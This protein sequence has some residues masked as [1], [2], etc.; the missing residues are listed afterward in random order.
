MSGHSKLTPVGKAAPV[1]AGK[2]S[3]RYRKT[4]ATWVIYHKGSVVESGFDS[5][6]SARDYLFD[7]FA[8]ATLDTQASKV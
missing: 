2:V 1:L 3:V 8:I 5:E 7:W 4:T 6:Q